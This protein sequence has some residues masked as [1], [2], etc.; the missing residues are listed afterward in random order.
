MTTILER[1]ASLR[2]GVVFTQNN[3]ILLVNPGLFS[4]FE[5]KHW[6]LLL[7]GIAGSLLSFR[8]MMPFILGIILTLDY[9]RA[10]KKTYLICAGFFVINAIHY[11]YTLGVR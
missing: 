7:V 5:V 9:S 3:F 6:A 1:F 8:I 4:M 10:D 11:L 2:D